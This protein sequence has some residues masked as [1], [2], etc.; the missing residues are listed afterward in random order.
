MTQRQ[1]YGSDW[2]RDAGCTKQSIL[3]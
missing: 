1:H 2:K 3:I